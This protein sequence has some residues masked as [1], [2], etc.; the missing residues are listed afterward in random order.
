MKYKICPFPEGNNFRTGKTTWNCSIRIEG[1][2][3]WV[4]QPYKRYISKKVMIT[5]AH[6]MMEKLFKEIKSC[7]EDKPTSIPS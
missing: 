1:K 2:D 6:R 5:A 4:I 7:T 3:G